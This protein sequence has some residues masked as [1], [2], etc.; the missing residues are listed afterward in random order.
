MYQPME[1][2]SDMRY[3]YYPEE[4]VYLLPFEELDMTFPY[5]RWMYY[6][7]PSF[8]SSYYSYD[9]PFNYPADDSS[10][11]N[12]PTIGED[13]NTP[14]DSKFYY[15]GYY[16]GDYGGDFAGYYGDY[17]IK[18]DKLYRT[19]PYRTESPNRVIIPPLYQSPKFDSNTY[20]NTETGFAGGRYSQRFSNAGSS[21][22]RGSI[23]GRAPGRFEGSIP[24]FGNDKKEK[25]V[26]D[27]DTLDKKN[28]CE[29]GTLVSSNLNPKAR[30]LYDTIAA[31]GG[32]TNVYKTLSCT[33]KNRIEGFENV[34]DNKGVHGYFITTDR[35][36]EM[37]PTYGNLFIESKGIVTPF[38]SQIQ[39]S[40]VSPTP[41]QNGDLLPLQ[42]GNGDL[43][44]L[45]NTNRLNGNKSNGNGL[46]G[47]GSNGNGLN[48]NGLNGNGLNGNGLNGNG[49][50]GDGDLIPL[51]NTNRL[52]GN[53]S[54]G[55][56]N[57]SNGNGNRLNGNGSNGNGSNENRSNGYGNGSNGNGSNGN[58][59][60]GNGSNGNGSN[61]NGSN[62]NGLLKRIGD[63]LD[64]L[65]NGN[66]LN[67]LN[68]NGLNKN[69]L[70]KNGLQ[71]D[72]L[73]DNTPRIITYA[74]LQNIAPNTS[75]TYPGYSLFARTQLD[76]PDDK[77]GY[78]INDDTVASIDNKSATS[79]NETN[80]M[81]KAIA[82]SGLEEPIAV[83]M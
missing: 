34:D 47:N 26:E 14:D 29:I 45:Q 22:R 42:N 53:K 75:Q 81:D 11:Y 69:G 82:R 16:G 50:N 3:V 63:S 68:Q 67:S 35:E 83:V 78:V 21:L 31:R 12:Y 54:N 60:N 52:N 49:L 46:N 37:E 23:Q 8:Y 48:G 32:N 57:K 36:V 10:V 59:S 44:P 38:E 70:Q 20:P 62:G 58:G 4:N 7:Y 27:F 72:I 2:P 33:S 9:W 61:G 1:S 13:N 77:F 79:S 24:A 64:E 55:N 74:E 39:D 17:S 76:Y 5:H 6:H 19:F 30:A 80:L 40:N 66:G 65:L 51:Q 71:N 56:G 15:G 25:V 43:M 73:V 41:L 28:A 18:T